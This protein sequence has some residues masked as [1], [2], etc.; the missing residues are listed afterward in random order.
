[1]ADALLQ[2]LL[3]SFK[4]LIVA[5]VILLIVGG[6]LVI[7]SKGKEK[8]KGY[9]CI[10][11]LNHKYKETTENLLSEILPKKAFKKFLKDQKTQDKKK[12]EKTEKYPK[13]FVL[14]FNG[15][16]KASGVGSLREEITAILNI[17]TPKDEVVIRLESPGGIVH[18]YGLAASQL[19]RIRE[20][21]IP[22]VVTVDKIAASGGYLMACVANKILAAPFATLG[23]IGVVAQLP[24]F[25]RFLK[26]KNIDFEQITAG[27]YKRTISMFGKNTDEGR[28][29]LREE[30]GDIH[31]LF[32]STIQEYRTTIDIEKVATG[33]IWTG[34]QALELKL[35][36]ELQTSDDYLL[37][38]SKTADLY[39]ICY[40][41][42][43]SLSE[44]LT[45]TA[46]AVKDAVSVVF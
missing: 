7:L 18:S 1:M 20:R 46:Q 45:S 32:K 13:V 22:L 12:S 8:L 10:K 16:M 5:L 43:K 4:A 36:D 31:T 26:D 3:F 44:K 25:H 34:K 17:A 15:D 11:N 42:K 2:L 28:E 19:A 14:N 9:L 27:N 39:E 30:I 24:N 21:K 37:E 38:K 29:K 41:A 23:S 40:H 6:I 33:E 35:V